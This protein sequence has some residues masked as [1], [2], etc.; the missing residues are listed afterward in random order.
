[1]NIGI[2]TPAPPRSRY[3]NRV[4]ALRWAQI[5][6]KLKHRVRVAQEYQQES[7]DL[8][9]ALHARR[10]YPAVRRFHR[11]YPKRPII[12]ALTGTDLYRDLPDSR[13]AQKSIEIAARLVVLQPLASR[14]LLP[15]LRHKVRVIY[16]SASAIPPGRRRMQTRNREFMVLVI[17]HL[18]PVKDPFRAALA[19]RQMPA[20]SRVS[21]VHLGAAMTADMARQAH[22]EMRVNPRY[23]WLGEQPAGR[24]RRLLER[25][26]LCVLSSKLEGGANVLS[27]AA[28]AD[29][30]VLASRI[31]GSVGILGPTYPGYFKVGDTHQLAKLL[32]CAETQPDFLARLK[33]Y[34]RRLAPRFDPA[35]EK[36]AWKRL[37]DELSG[38]GR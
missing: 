26:A 1:M 19:A 35:R 8:L 23:R 36:A 22:A 30:P 5:L 17:G 29:V 38:S 34:A 24:V 25:S 7:Y 11:L 9:I 15:R 18:R 14:E 31:P 28:V 32:A 10:S 4:T 27:E 2:I 12:V 13:A 21:V 16:Q 3:G 6:K 20:S 37:L 33:V